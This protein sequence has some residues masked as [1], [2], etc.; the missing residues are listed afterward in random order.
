MSNDINIADFIVHLHPESSCDDREKVEQE[1]RSHDGVVSVHFSE[2]DHPH[3]MIVAFNPEV[4][5]S[6]DLLEGIRKCD[7]QAMIAGI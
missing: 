7:P 1:L 2:E 6:E 4:A 5:T 3:A